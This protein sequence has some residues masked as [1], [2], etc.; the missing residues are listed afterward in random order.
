LSLTLYCRAF[1][2]PLAAIALLLGTPA[3]AY[4]HSP[5]LRI[6]EAHG[7]AATSADAKET[8]A[9]QP[10]SASP[11]PPATTTEHS[12]PVAGEKIDYT[13]EAGTIALPAKAGRPEAEIFYVA[14]RRK[15]ESAKRPITFVFNGGPGAAAITPAAAAAAGHGPAATGQRL[16]IAGDDCRRALRGGVARLLPAGLRRTASE[17]GAVRRRR[18][19]GEQILGGSQR[20]RA[21][22]RQRRGSRNVQSIH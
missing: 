13:A 12:I 10:D 22:H 19:A 15:P 11:L 7:T 6:A 9:K 5:D 4:D 20:G 1:L 17:F 21:S 8:E 3:Q 18:N 14:Y 2:A 16:F